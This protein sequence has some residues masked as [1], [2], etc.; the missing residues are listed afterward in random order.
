M[1]LRVVVHVKPGARQRKLVKLSD[2]EYLAWVVSP[3]R[4][5]RANKELIELISEELRIPRSKIRIIR[6]QSSR[7]KVLEIEI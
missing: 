2:S 5:G 3:P 4:R 7:T 1:K 6:G